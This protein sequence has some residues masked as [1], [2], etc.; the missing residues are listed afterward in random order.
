MTD[1]KKRSYYDN[2]IDLFE[3]F[4]SV[5]NG[6]WQIIGFLL[7]FTLI[8]FLYERSQSTNFKISADVS[9]VSGS[10]FSKYI[11]LNDVLSESPLPFMEDGIK[12]FYEITPNSVLNQ[13]V[14]QFTNR[15]EIIKVLSQKK[16]L[17]VNSNKDDNFEKQIL[18]SAKSFVISSNSEKSQFYKIT[19]MWPKFSQII[20][21]GNSIIE[22]TLFSV[23][24]I[25]LD[26]LQFIKS[27]ID[28]KN[29]RVIDKIKFDIRM[30]TEHVEKEIKSKLIFL[31][32]QS[33]IAQKLGMK[34]N[35][36]DG[37]SLN[38]TQLQSRDINIITT[39]TP[40]YLRGYEAI[41]QEIRN[42]ENRSL[43]DRLFLSKDY[44]HLLKE[45][46]DIQ[47]DLASSQVANAIKLFADED[48]R[49]W[50]TYNVE[51][52]EI[53]STRNKNI[54]II[55]SALLGLFVGIFFVLIVN[56][57]RKRYRQI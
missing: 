11:I 8:G 22:E 55:F 36:L 5:W 57:I 21:L 52:A 14:L 3:I 49:K 42:I 37:E 1:S 19:F 56:A 17:D 39:N 27:Y 6:K 43:S 35:T 31:R 51:F 24:Q 15:N 25:I 20:D 44:L 10:Q 16:Y 38:N 34:D 12:N 18:N 33:R 23:R 45:L 46:R 7:L 4:Q 2:E 28:A 47:N 9:A 48:P 40:Y 50:I 29:Q 41:D 30:L 26:D 53:S 54:I 32:E 13:F